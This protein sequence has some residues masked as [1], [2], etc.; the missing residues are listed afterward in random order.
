MSAVQEPGE[1]SSAA[2][3]VVGQPRQ[4]TL[5]DGEVPVVHSVSR[6]GRQTTRIPRPSHLNTTS[7]DIPTQNPSAPEQSPVMVYSRVSCCH[8][9][10][11][12]VAT[13]CCV[14]RSEPWISL[15][16]EPS[17]TTGMPYPPPLFQTQGTNTD[18]TQFAGS[19]AARPWSGARGHTP[20][21]KKEVSAGPVA[22]LHA[23]HVCFSMCQNIRNMHCFGLT[24]CH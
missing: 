23:L 18:Q 1:S 22:Q 9:T 21:L 15:Q 6:F 12:A 2:D 16:V 14:V 17:P 10:T 7:L 3:H 24:E 5:F 13:V 11:A 20:T 19:A 8:S 4:S